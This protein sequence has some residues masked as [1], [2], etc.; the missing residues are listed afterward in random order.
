MSEAMLSHLS[1]VPAVYMGANYQRKAMTRSTHVH[2]HCHRSHQPFLLKIMVVVKIFGSVDN[3]RVGN[4][5]Y[6]YLLRNRLGSSF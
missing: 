1:E 6:I 2:V 4:M 3:V 5:K